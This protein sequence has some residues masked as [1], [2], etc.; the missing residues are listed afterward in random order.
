MN[1]H[2]ARP[3]CFTDEPSTRHGPP[4]LQPD[5][6]YRPWPGDAT[7]CGNAT[8]D[9]WPRHID[10]TPGCL[11]CGAGYEARVMAGQG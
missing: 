8:A 3:A 7:W 10:M 5:G 9:Y 2:T 1:R 4:A 11:G 6:T